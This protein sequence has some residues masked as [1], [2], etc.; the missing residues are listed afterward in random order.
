MIIKKLSLSVIFLWITL[1][2]SPTFAADNYYLLKKGASAWD[3]GQLSE[4]IG[5]YQE[6]IDH[7]PATTH[8]FSDTYQQRKQYHLRNLLIAYKNLLEIYD[9]IRDHTSKSLWLDHLESLGSEGSLGAKNL[10]QAGWILLKHQR[11]NAAA[12]IFESIVAEQC[13]AYNPNHNKVL[14]RSCVKLIEIYQQKG[15]VLKQADLLKRIQ[16]KFPTKDFD[17]RDLY[18]LANF[19]QNCGME[20]E[21][22]KLLH[23]I[24]DEDDFNLSSPYLHARMDAYARLLEIA[25]HEDKA[26]WSANKS[27]NALRKWIA[28]LSQKYPP[29]SLPAAISYKLAVKYLQYDR[30]DEGIRLLEYISKEH[31]KGTTGR[32]ALFLLGRVAQS[33]ENWDKA[34]AYFESYIHQYPDPLFFAL[35]AYSR[36]IDAYWSKDADIK[37]A[38]KD[39]GLLA[40]IVNQVADYETQL[41]LSRDLKWMGM[42]QLAEATFNLGANAAEKEAQKHTGTYKALRIRWLITKYAQ[43]IERYD[44]AEKNGKMALTLARQL[45]HQNREKSSNKPEKTEYIESQIYLWL[46]KIYETQE[47]YDEAEPLLRLFMNKYPDDKENA[48]AGY[49]LGQVLEKLGRVQ[50]A[51]DTYSTVSQGMWKEKAHKRVVELSSDSGF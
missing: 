33:Q 35:K 17:P 46:A 39:A 45:N 25:Y 34:I 11:E 5:F 49:A 4:A 20:I 40:D 6:Y 47:R 30:T 42:D 16:H 41:N 12:S 2:I 44:L 23:R 10:Y 50:D 22:K 3:A 28:H 14:L 9:Q 19:Y 24:A 37:L 32:K 43:A 36:M 29:E 38:Q 27:D 13:E 26:A 48:Y 18:R 21:S 31:S 7:H 1:I 51:A 15:E 8:I